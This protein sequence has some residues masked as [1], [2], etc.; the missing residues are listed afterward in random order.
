ML[1][2]SI[3]PAPVETVELSADLDPG[4]YTVV[5]TIGGDNLER[6]LSIA[7]TPPVRV[8]VQPG[9]G[10]AW[11]PA[12]GSIDIPL[13]AGGAVDV[14]IGVLAG[15]GHPESVPWQQLLLVQD[16]DVPWQLQLETLP[17]GVTGAR[18][19]RTVRIAESP[20]R[21]TVGDASFALV[22]RPVSVEA[23]AA[24][25]TAGDLAFPAEI[26]GTPD[27]GRPQGRVALPSQIGRAHV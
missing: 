25:L 13:V 27:L 15:P 12:T 5:A 26:D 7:P 2:R 22:P 16:P 1:F 19:V 3:P 14:T 17:L 6:S 11:L 23:L 21:L 4:T 18:V 10:A 20:V 9:P 8:E 24:T